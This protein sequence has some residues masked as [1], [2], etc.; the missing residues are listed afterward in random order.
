MHVKDAARSAP[1]MVGKPSDHPRFAKRRRVRY[2]NERGLAFARAMPGRRSE[3]EQRWVDC[4]LPPCVSS[5]VSCC[6]AD[7]HA[8]D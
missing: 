6:R 5:R 1:A 7:H 3:I 2:A 8:N 4:L